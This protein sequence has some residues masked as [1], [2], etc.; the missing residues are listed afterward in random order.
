MQ[1]PG[2]PAGERLQRV[3]ALRR[4]GVAA[5]ALRAR[6]ALEPHRQP[7]RLA[8]VRQMQRQ[9]FYSCFVSGFILLK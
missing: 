8:H 5:A 9:V 3:P 6:P 7:V 2:L 4:V 1:Q